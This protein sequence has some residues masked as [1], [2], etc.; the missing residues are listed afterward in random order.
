M[1]VLF[2]QQRELYRRQ[3]YIYRAELRSSSFERQLPN[4]AGR[5][6]YFVRGDCGGV[7]FHQPAFSIAT[8]NVTFPQYSINGVLF[9]ASLN[10]ILS[11]GQPQINVYL[12]GV[13][14]NDGFGNPMTL[15]KEP[16]LLK[17]RAKSGATDISFSYNNTTG[18]NSIPGLLLGL[19]T[20][21]VAAGW[22]VV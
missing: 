5:N 18:L 19:S 16:Q 2:L 20:A 4:L 11:S 6:C 14:Q 15:E 9:F 13:G 10:G 7:Q 8:S 3:P 1:A 22:V 21:A 12:R 17:M